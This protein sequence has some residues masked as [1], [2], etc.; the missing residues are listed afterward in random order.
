MSRSRG[1]GPGC[2][3]RRDRSTPVRW[4][5][6]VALHRPRMSARRLLHHTTNRTRQRAQAVRW[7]RTSAGNSER[8]VPLRSRLRPGY[9]GEEIASLFDVNGA[10]T[11]LARNAL[12]EADALVCRALRYRA[13]HRPACRE[14]R[15]L[16]PE[17]ARN[18]PATP[19]HIL[20]P[21]EEEAGQLRVSQGLGFECTAA[22][23]P[24]IEHR[25]P[26]GRR[27]REEA[28]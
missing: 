2:T 1:S 20:V 21:A 26:E 24:R 4:L 14:A 15:A 12:R 10:S 9:L 22:L 5:L 8:V 3:G 28:L 13:A 23:E 16:G 18:A 25:P 7:V 19:D 17:G 6:Q 11:A 27:L